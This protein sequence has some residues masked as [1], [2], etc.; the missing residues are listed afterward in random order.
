M[1]IY[2]EK[3]RNIYTC[4]EKLRNIKTYFEKWQSTDG[5][6]VLLQ[7]LEKKSRWQIVYGGNQRPGGKTSSIKLISTSLGPIEALS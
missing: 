7:H 6:P 5:K 4:F 1:H 2:F 3:F